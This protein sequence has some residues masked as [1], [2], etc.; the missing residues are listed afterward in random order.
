MLSEE[1]LQLTNSDFLKN[2]AKYYNDLLE[3]QELS[4]IT[5]ACDGYQVGAHKTILSA[6]SEFFRE[7]IRKSKHVNPYIYLKGVSKESLKSLL[8]FIYVGEATANN[9][10]LE[11][12]VDAGNELKIVGIMKESTIVDVREDPIGTKKVKETEKLQDTEPDFQIADIVKIEMEDVDNENVV[13]EV[14]DMNEHLEREI[15]KR[16]TFKIDD[17][18]T[19]QYVCTICFKEMRL[20]PKMKLHIEIHLEGFSHKCKFCRVVKKTRRALHCHLRQYHG[21]ETEENYQ[22]NVGFDGEILVVLKE[23]ILG[24]FDP[25]VDLNP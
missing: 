5:L 9:E 10:D 21:S 1:T 4:D 13:T 14:D 22:E 7:V 18:G 6:S 3:S 20:K 15:A 16:M 19:K 12:L 25:R 11:N 23:V 24:G 2:Q 8:T 17:N